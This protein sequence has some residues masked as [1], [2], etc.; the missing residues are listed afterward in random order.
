VTFDSEGNDNP[1]S[2]YFSRKPHWPGGASGV[3]IG[4][5]YDMK[6]R[7]RDEI[8]S[9]L[10]AAGV[11]RRAT[12]KLS[13][14]AGLEG[15]KASRFAHR[16]RRLVLTAAQQNLLFEQVYRWYEMETQRLVCKWEGAADASCD[17]IW[18]RMDGS[19]QELLIDLRYRG[20]LTRTRWTSWLSASAASNDLTAFAAV[21]GDREV[22]S[23]VPPDRFNRRKTHAD[24]AL[25]VD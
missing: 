5:G 6:F 2:R 18:M 12:R 8:R 23:A 22:W 1:E 24:A 20:D 16:K 14:G 7:T 13:K 17:A 10:T 19:I 21:M 15:R 11:S 9:D 25:P 4:R 3:T